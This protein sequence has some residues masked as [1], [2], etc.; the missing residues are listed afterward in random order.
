[1]SH[2]L[3]FCAYGLGLLRRFWEPREP[4]SGDATRPWIIE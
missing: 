2:D 3:Y 1:L 4:E